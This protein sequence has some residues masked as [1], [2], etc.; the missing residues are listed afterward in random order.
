[1]ETDLLIKKIQSLSPHKIAEVEDFVDFLSYRERDR[2]LIHA[3]G[4]L[5]GDSIK[6]IWDNPEAAEYD[7]L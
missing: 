3:A 7:R 1:M 5:A 6:Q 4:K 2:A